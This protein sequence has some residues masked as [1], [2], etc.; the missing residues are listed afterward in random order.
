MDTFFLFVSHLPKPHP[1]A[2]ARFS[3]KK[4]GM[5]IKNIEIESEKA[6][7]FTVPSNYFKETSHK[8][9]DLPYFIHCIVGK[10][11]ENLL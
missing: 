4:H 11:M 6:C 10:I 3:Q 2:S 8:H 7:S 5:L 1:M 9:L